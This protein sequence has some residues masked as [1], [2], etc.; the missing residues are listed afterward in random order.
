[1]FMD[2]KDLYLNN[3]MPLSKWIRISV[4]INPKELMDKYNLYEK[5]HNGYI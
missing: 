3:N 2:V 4:M 5:F 1:M